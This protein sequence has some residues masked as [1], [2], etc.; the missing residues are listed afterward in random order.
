[1]HFVSL[2][3]LVLIVVLWLAPVTYTKVSLAIIN[4]DVHTFATKPSGRKIKIR[5]GYI[6]HMMAF[7]S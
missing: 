4:V 7:K 6:Q 3:L 1:M 5:T 2:K